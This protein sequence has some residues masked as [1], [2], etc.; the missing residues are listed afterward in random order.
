[1]PIP[2][3]IAAAIGGL[4]MIGSHQQGI[5]ERAHQ[6]K[7]Y[8]RQHQDAIAFWERQ[9]EYNLPVNQRK[10]LQDAGLNPALMYKGGAG[11]GGNAGT[12]NHPDF[13]GGL[14]RQPT[15]NDIAEAISLFQDVRI[16]Q[17]QTRVFDAN[18]VSASEDAVTK[19]MLN[20]ELRDRLNH[21]AIFKFQSKDGRSYQGAILDAELRAKL[22]Q[23]DRSAAGGQLAKAQADFLNDI[24]KM[25]GVSETQKNM[26]KVLYFLGVK[27]FDK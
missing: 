1:M 7:L 26:L 16:K 13:V 24:E 3:G 14:T 10:R 9:N 19:A 22:G 12:I 18:A 21:Q 23:A 25:K 5:R 20:N 15:F 6:M 8:Q 27:N 4:G 17:A 11:S 2:V